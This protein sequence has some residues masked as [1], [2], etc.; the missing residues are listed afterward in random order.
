MYGCL[1][2]VLKDGLRIRTFHHF[3]AKMCNVTHWSSGVKLAGW[4]VK[5]AGWGIY[6]GA[7]RNAVAW[8]VK[9]SGLSDADLVV[10]CQ[11]SRLGND[12]QPG[13]HT[14][15][16]LNPMRP[17]KSTCQLLCRDWSIHCQKQNPALSYLHWIMHLY[18]SHCP[19][20][21]YLILKTMPLA[22]A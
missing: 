15:A 14:R 12:L 1:W 7:L 22:F 21:R 11:I 19:R 13:V 6:S 18:N 5:L 4:G 20:K 16:R 17:S 8:A 2:W 10:R 9:C 3:S